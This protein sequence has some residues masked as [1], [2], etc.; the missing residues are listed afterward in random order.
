MSAI[1]TGRV[2]WTP[3]KDLSYTD[4]KGEKFSIKETTAKI[5]MLAIADS[6]DDYGENSWQSFETIAQKASIQRRSAIRAVRAL[7]AHGYLT[8]AGISR[9]GTNNFTVNKDLLGN[10]PPRRAK[11]G[12]PKT[13]DPE[14]FTSDSGAKTSDPEAKTGDSPSP[15]P[16]LNPPITTHNPGAHAPSLE[17]MPLDW[18]IAAG[19][20]T[21]TLPDET[22]SRMKDA[23]NLI[24]M[25]MGVISTP[26]YELA[27][28]FMK[29][30][31]IV[32]APSRLKGQRKA[33]REMIEAKVRPEHVT[34]AVEQLLSKGMT[35]TDLYSV[36]KTAT[37]LANPAPT[38]QEDRP[39]YR[40]FQAKDDGN[41]IPNPYKKPRIA[42]G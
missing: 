4:K 15:Y 19:Q 35:V 33:I 26:A 41:Y 10:V 8:V 28:A 17:E 5:V 2:F 38:P 32:I 42:A 37:D 3:F 18:Q 25:G 11:A 30:R 27:L 14:A 1:I 23:A 9:Y 20:E 12:R 34:Q 29:A 16:S 39:E 24:A 31:S 36:S 13:S 7:V 21:V 40:P 22:D 6:A